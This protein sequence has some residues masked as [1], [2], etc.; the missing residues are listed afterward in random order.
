MSL[1]SLPTSNSL[2]HLKKYVS[3]RGGMLA[4]NDME[5]F[6]AVVDCLNQAIRATSCLNLDLDYSDEYDYVLEQFEN[7]F[8]HQSLRKFVESKIRGLALADRITPENDPDDLYFYDKVLRSVVNVNFEMMIGG[9]VFS[10]RAVQEEHLKLFNGGSSMIGLNAQSASSSE[11]QGCGDQVG[12]GISISSISLYNHTGLPLQKSFTAYYKLN[13]DCANLGGTV[14]FD[15]TVTDTTNTV[16]NSATTTSPNWSF[17]AFP[18]YGQ[19]KVCVRAYIE[20]TSCEST[21]C[22]ITVFVKEPD[23]DST[24]CKTFSLDKKDDVTSSNGK[25]RMKTRLELVS[26]SWLGIPYNG[27]TGQSKSY[28]KIGGTWKWRKVDRL[29]LM[30]LGE[31]HEFYCNGPLKMATTGG[32]K[33]RYN[34]R[35]IMA[36]DYYWVPVFVRQ[37]KVVSTHILLN[38]SPSASLLDNRKLAKC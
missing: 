35:Q 9:K 1:T 25:V 6:R 12:F 27:F 34:K 5:G 28:K 4:F 22:C 16:V 18:A 20:G 31:Y 33:D 38:N 14:Q 36:T 37:N 13:G 21:E 26:L 10:L 24:C 30:F 15:W 19:Y 11:S 23:D 8:G 32:F 17:V 2:S 29:R 7:I 3:L